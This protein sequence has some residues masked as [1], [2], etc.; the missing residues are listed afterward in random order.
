MAR[1][2]I[3]FDLMVGD[4]DPGGIHSAAKVRRPGDAIMQVSGLT[5]G[6]AVKGVDLTLH[7]GEILGVAGLQGQGQ[8]ELL[9]V[10]AGFRPSSGGR[11]T[12]M[13]DVSPSIRAT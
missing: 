2:Q 9:E 6:S 4:H 13:G 5:S 1:R 3:F 7:E 8:E 10:I 12:H 11:I